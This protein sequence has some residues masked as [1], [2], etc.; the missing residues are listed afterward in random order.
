MVN[1][2]VQSGEFGCDVLRIED[3][4]AVAVASVTVPHGNTYFLSDVAIA[5]LLCTELLRREAIGD[6]K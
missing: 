5:E 1:F 3:G 2:V 6:K 4:R